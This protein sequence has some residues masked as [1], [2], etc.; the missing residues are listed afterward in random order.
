MTTESKIPFETKPRS[1]RQAAGKAIR[2]SVPRSAHAAWKPSPNRTDIISL[3]EQSNQD[4]LPDLI[5]LRYRRMLQSPLACL[6]GSAIVMAEDLAG[7]PKTNIRLQVCGDCHLQ[8]FGW[9][10]SPERNL[11]FDVNDFDETLNAPW[12]WDVKRLVASVVVAARGLN[13]SKS[14]QQQLGQAV[15]REYRAHL[16]AVLARRALAKATA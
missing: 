4:R 8:N 9:F 16:A 1:E 7:L 5:S 12:E 2:E 11:V 14:D 13:A 6:R 3:L 15:A 10:A